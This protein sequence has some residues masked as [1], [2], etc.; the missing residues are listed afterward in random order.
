MLARH[1]A[2]TNSLFGRG[3]VVLSERGRVRF[4]DFPS[5]L[6]DDYFLDSLFASTEKR[7]VSEVVSVVGAP[8]TATVLV[9]RLARVRRG[10]REVRGRHDSAPGARR[11]EGWRWL[12]DAIR[13][14]PTFAL[15]AA[16][17][18]AVTAYVIAVSRLARVS[19]GHDRGRPLQ[20][21]D[22]PGEPA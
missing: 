19:W 8:S 4:A 16:V 18:A 5:V 7:V 22:A 6:A 17:Y 2:F 10:N 14:A 12:V 11:V 13:T 1:P 21:A 9:R 3:V 15:S 20:L